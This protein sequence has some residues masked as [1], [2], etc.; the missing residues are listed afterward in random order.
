MTKR[1]KSVV[2]DASQNDDIEVG[3]SI[4]ISPVI[5][6]KDCILCNEAKS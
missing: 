5:F 2:K 3:L 6:N 1:S 4:N